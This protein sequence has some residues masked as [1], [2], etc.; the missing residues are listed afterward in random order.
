MKLAI[1]KFISSRVLM[2]IVNKIVSHNFDF[3]NLFLYKIEY[4]LLLIF[5]FLFK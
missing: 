3:I 2:K 4:L 1:N 5:K